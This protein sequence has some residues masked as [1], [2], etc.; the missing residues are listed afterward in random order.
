MARFTYTVLSRAVPGR[1]DEFAEWYST[2]HLADVRRMPG[3]V[4]AKLFRLDFQRVYDLDAP[5]WTLMTI[6][7]LEGDDHE[8]IIDRI[9]AAS[10]S[11]EMP[12]SDALTKL[13]MVQVAG[14]LIAEA[15]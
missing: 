7:E 4:G 11:A 1:E 6:Y 2:Q 15:A 13:G 10:G 12:A 14:H 3:V 9:K 8:T 5:Q